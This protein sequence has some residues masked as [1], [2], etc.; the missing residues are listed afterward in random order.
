MSGRF[1]FG[2]IPGGL[3]NAALASTTI[4]SLQ[5]F[6]LGLAQSYQQ[7]FGDGVVGGT[8]PLYAGYVQDEWR[9][10]SSLTLSAGLRYEVD[11]RRAPLPTD[12]NKLAPR[13]GFA[14]SPDSKTVLRGGYGIYYA[15]IDFQI[16]YSVY[17]LGVTPNGFRP[18]AQVLTTIQTP[19][20]QSAAN[21]FSTLR[22][23][24]VIGI[25]TPT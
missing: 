22:A 17:A 7:G 10:T 15:T 23:Q 3:V 18:I 1:T 11:K 20:A 25:P 9:A 21:I 19:G 12:H 4:T 5:A 6:N 24:G 13:F 8:L 14:W 2:P 16:D